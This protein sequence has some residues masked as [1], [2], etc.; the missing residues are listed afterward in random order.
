MK[1]NN[2]NPNTETFQ[3]IIDGLSQRGDTA[4]MLKYMGNMSMFNASPNPHIFNTI[5]L[6]LGKKGDTEEVISLIKRM[7]ARKVRYK[8]ISHNIKL[9]GA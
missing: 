8:C 6:A 1:Q 3:Y 5:L 7:E 2:T 4:T 9:T